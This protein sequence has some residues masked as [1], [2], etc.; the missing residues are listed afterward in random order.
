M[1]ATDIQLIDIDG[2]HWANWYELLMPPRLRHYRLRL[3][4][5][6]GNTL[7]IED[8]YRFPTTLGDLDLYL[9]GEGSDKQIY[10]KLG[11]QLRTVAGISGTRFAVCGVSFFA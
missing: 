8:P 9:F 1:L 7:D 6:A 5:T 3:T 11:A 10:A 4:I 2:R